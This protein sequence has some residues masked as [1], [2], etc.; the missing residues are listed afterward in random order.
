MVAGDIITAVDGT[1][2]TSADELTTILEGHAPGDQVALTWI[3]TSDAA[4]TAT[5]TLAQGPAA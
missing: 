5:V 1:A 2:V 4:Q 3:D